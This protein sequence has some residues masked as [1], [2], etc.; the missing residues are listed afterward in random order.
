MTTS[1]VQ[2]PIDVRG[3]RLV[4]HDHGGPGPRALF[5]HGYLDTGR[6]FDAVAALLTGSARALC[7][8]QRGYGRSDRA[9]P[10][11]SYHLLDLLKDLDAV[12][13]AVD[14][15]V[16]VA[17][18]MG[19]NVA[20]L[21]AGARPER[22]KRLVLVDSLGAPPEEPDAQPE[23]LG[24]LLRSLD[25][26]PKPFPILPGIDEAAA[27]IAKN[28]VGLSATGARRMAEAAVVPVSG[29]VAFTFDPR[30]KGPVPVRWPESMWLSLCAR[31]TADVVLLRARA[32]YVGDDEQ[33]A[34]R[35]AALR[36]TKVEVDGG[37]HLHVERPEVIADAVRALLAGAV[38]R[39]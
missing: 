37:H 22:V 21:L 36:A 29:G 24:Q 11:G 6:S 27:R 5:V 25:D 9:G 35:L 2:L 18:S 4:V 26:E 17:H 34:A 1:P 13:A 12:T 31:V 7:L 15:D 28:N 30:V 33:S 16:I 20:L 32:G 23:R 19:G 10:G 14:P 38:P 8:D 3:L 39:R